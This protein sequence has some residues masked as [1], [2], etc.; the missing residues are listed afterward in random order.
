M[1]FCCQIFWCANHKYSCNVYQIF[2]C[3]NHEYSCVY[4]KYSDAP[5]INIHVMFIKSSDVQ[6]MYIHVFMSNLQMHQSWIFYNNATFE[7]PFSWLF[8]VNCVFDLS[9]NQPYPHYLIFKLKSCQYLLAGWSALNCQSII[10]FFREEDHLSILHCLT[11]Q[12]FFFSVVPFSHLSAIVSN[13]Y[14]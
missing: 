4:V 3:A 10:H 1:Y 6:I 5:I 13:P 9:I 8:Q 14:N 11:L 12:V 7:S 2:W